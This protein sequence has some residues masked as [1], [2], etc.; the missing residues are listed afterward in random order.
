MDQPNEYSRRSFVKFLAASAVTMPWLAMCSG[1]TERKVHLS[2]RIRLGIIGIGSRGAKL[3]LHLQLI[4][5]AEIVAVC[6]DYYPHLT[7]AKQLTKGTARTFSDYHELLALPD[8]D[9]V[10]IATPPHLHAA[11]TID[12]LKAGK[13]V[14]CEKAMAL[15][16]DDCLRMVHAHKQTGKNLQ[17]GFQRLFDLRFIKAVEMVRQ[18]LI[19]QVTMVRAWWHRNNDWRVTV[20]KPELERRMNWRLYR[21]TSGGLAMELAAHQIQVAN[22]LLNGYP[23]SIMGVGSINYWNDSRDVY[24][25]ISLILQYPN[26]V[27][28]VY[29]ALI[30]N[31][32]HGMAQQILGV[33]GTIELEQGKW[34]TKD[35]PPPAPGILQLI[36]NIEHGIFDT[37]PIGGPSWIPEHPVDYKGENI[38]DQHPIP[39]PTQLELEAFVQSIRQGKQIPDVLEQAFYASVA[40][41]LANN[42][43]DTQQPVK[44]PAE[45]V[46]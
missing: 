42:A 26:G 18:G 6:D 39:E 46:L 5:E 20:P 43:M 23:Q 19:G 3:L 32:H 35:G 2:G 36:N 14:F 1:T 13:H 38:I 40:S 8:L 33:K 27:Q 15:R 9:G 11:M 12:A 24:D 10:V 34:Y 21:N 16:P 22:W 7:N 25:N 31:K 29:D 41:I 4:P 28:L 37:I 44:W 30:S 17:I 45:C